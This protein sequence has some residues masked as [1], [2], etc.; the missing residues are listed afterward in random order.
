MLGKAQLNAHSKCHSSTIPTT[1]G[2]KPTPVFKKEPHFI[3]CPERRSYKTK[4]RPGPI[5]VR[6]FCWSIGGH[7][8]LYS[9]NN[10][11]CFHGLR[12]RD[13]VHLSY[14]SESAISVK[15][16]LHRVDQLSHRGDHPRGEKNPGAAFTASRMLPRCLRKESLSSGTL[17]RLYHAS[18]DRTSS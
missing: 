6:I 10:V 7:P 18:D 3:K 9:I 15:Q 1:R 5:L 8:R 17:R 16:A 14:S 4:L 11:S 12:W 13:A 2:M